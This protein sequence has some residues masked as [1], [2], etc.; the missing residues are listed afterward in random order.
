MMDFWDIRTA[1]TVFAYVLAVSFLG[2]FAV[3]IV[4]IAMD[5]IDLSTIIMEK[6]GSEKSS[7]S[8]FQLLVFTLTIAGLYV[9]LS[10]EN[11]QLIDVPNGALS[12]LGISG[13][14][15]LLSKAIGKPGGGDG[16]AKGGPRAP[17]GGG[18][19]PAPLGGAGGQGQAPQVGAAGAPGAAPGQGGVQG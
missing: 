16:P 14:S 9:I 4:K 19:A 10:I 17:A 5:K 2:M 1:T 11:G 6:D 15:F 7:I 18:H 3:V 13:G 8:R 12:L